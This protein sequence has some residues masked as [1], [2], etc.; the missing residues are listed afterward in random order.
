MHPKAKY[1]LQQWYCE[2]PVGINTLRETVKCLATAAGLP[3]KFTNHSLRVTAATRLYQEGVS[4]KLIK[5]ITGHR[6]EA[7][8]DYERTG[9]A[10]KRSVSAALGTNPDK[11]P[12]KRKERV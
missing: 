6:S 2:H 7:V 3:G 1:N 12:C 8:R 5:E 10:M 11:S 4:E 9:E